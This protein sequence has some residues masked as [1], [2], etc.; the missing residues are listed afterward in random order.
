MYSVPPSP[1]LFS[2]PYAILSVAIALVST[3]GPAALVSM[4]TL[5][6]TPAAAMRPLAPRPGKRILLERIKPLWYRLSFLPKVTARNLFRYKKRALM[7]LIGVAGCTGLMFTGFGLNDSLAT[8]GPK[9]YGQIQRFDVAVTFKTD[10]EP[11]ETERLF[12]FVNQSAD[13]SQ[14]TLA[15][16][17]TAEVVGQTQSR[18]LALIVP[19]DPGGFHDYY[20]LNPSASKTAGP[21]S[22]PLQPYTLSDE[23]VILTDQISRQIGVTIG[24]TVTL[25]TLNNDEAQFVVIGIMENYVYH[26]AFITPAAYEQ[27]FDKKPTTNQIL[28]LLAPESTGLPST[29]TDL[30]VVSGVTN[31][32]RSATSFSSITDVLGFVMAILILSAATLAFVVL[33]S[34]NT[35]NR[36]ERARE[37][38]SIKVLGFFNR[39]IASYIYRE[40]LIL[41]IFGVI[42]GLAF[43]VVLERYIITT[44]EVDVFMF[45]RDLL[46]PSYLY[47][48]LLTILFAIIVNLLIYRPLT[49]IDMVSSLKAVE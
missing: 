44:I 14:Y 47:S 36:E 43:G 5:R 38:A 28:C 30:P 41:T 29:I 7:T 16:R 23:G 11:Y 45:S 32:E 35:I 17:E 22:K 46:I 19:D 9:Q 18:D 34:L 8:V 31:T 37:L 25:R 2:W 49:N 39:E 15:H 33:F 40:G 12:D 27:G 42:L 20:A 24:D 21:F 1:A 6:E 13:I 4:Q 3:V 10:V 26:Y 48:S